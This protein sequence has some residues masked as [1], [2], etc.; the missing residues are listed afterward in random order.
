MRLKDKKLFLLDMD[1]T[2]YIGDTL[3]EGA[4]EFLN[5]VRVNRGDYL[6]LSNNSS[7][8]KDA[9][10]SKMERFGISANEHE[11]IS[12]V[13]V[14]I[15]YLKEKYPEGTRIYLAGTSTTVEQ[16]RAAGLKIE[17]KLPAGWEDL[18]DVAVLSYDTEITYK[19][20]EEFTVML[21]KGKDY[22]ATHPDMLCPANYGM[23]VDIGCYIDMFRTATGRIPLIIGKP[24][25]QMVYKALKKSGV[26]PEDAVIIGDRLHTDI[27]CGV[28]AG[29]DTIFVL[30]G[31]HKREDIDKYGIKP[32][33]IFDSIKDVYEEIK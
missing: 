17:E 7:R 27:A 18:P 15:D 12:S 32:T 30:S 2:L 29:I 26:K 5:Q 8:G 14:T 24:Q 21:M 11:F 19:K 4:K 13:D 22:I 16:M 3:I 25:P 20:I 9:Y 23:A 31:D 33:Y 10:V 1:G 28:N 6:Y